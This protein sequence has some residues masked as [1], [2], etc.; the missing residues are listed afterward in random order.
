MVQERVVYNGT[1]CPVLF[2]ELNPGLIRPGRNGSADLQSAVSQRYSRPQVCA[3]TELIIQLAGDTQAGNAAEMLVVGQDN[4]A[5]AFRAAG[6][7][8]VG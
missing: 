2:D 1:S 6:D 7:D 5:H 4:R 3:T 8:N